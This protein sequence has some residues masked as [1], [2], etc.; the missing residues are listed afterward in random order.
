[1]GDYPQNRYRLRSIPDKF[2]IQTS[3]ATP[4]NRKQPPL[5]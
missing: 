2:A 1:M 3:G 5:L 4:Y